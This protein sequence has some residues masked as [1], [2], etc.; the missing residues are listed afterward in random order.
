MR[1]CAIIS[2][3]REQHPFGHSFAALRAPCHAYYLPHTLPLSFLQL[4]ARL[5]PL[6]RS[7]LGFPLP[8]HTPVSLVHSDAKLVLFSHSFAHLFPPCPPPASLSSTPLLSPQVENIYIPNP[9][10]LLYYTL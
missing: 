6:L 3:L 5:F 1:E 8:C 2:P 7:V 9:P 10:I 4:G